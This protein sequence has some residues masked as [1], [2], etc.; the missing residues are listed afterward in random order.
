MVKFGQSRAKKALVL[1]LIFAVVFTCRE[2]NNP[3]DPEVDLKESLPDVF[4]IEVI[5]ENVVK[6][7]WDM[8]DKNIDGFVVERRT[9]DGKFKELKRTNVTD[10]HDKDIIRENNYSYRIK[11]K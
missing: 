7:S 1:L 6:L 3:Y 10:F 5:S 9:N 8:P 11:F 4:N 2:F